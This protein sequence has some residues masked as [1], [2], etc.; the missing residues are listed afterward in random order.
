MIRSDTIT[1]VPG[2]QVGSYTVGESAIALAALWLMS[3]CIESMAF[4]RG[5]MRAA[6]KSSAREMVHHY[7]PPM[8]G[9]CSFDLR[10][11]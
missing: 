11:R 1:L 10:W 2:W 6:G 3:I 9:G 7:R 8:T 4:V 5:A